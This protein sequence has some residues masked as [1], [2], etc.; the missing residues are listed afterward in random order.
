[1]TA[2]TFDLSPQDSRMLQDLARLVGKDESAFAGD[3]VRS[4]LGRQAADSD[5]RAGLRAMEKLRSETEKRIPRP[6]STRAQKSTRSRVAQGRSLA[7][8]PDGL[9]VTFEGKRAR[10]ESGQLELDGVR[11][12]SPSPAAVRAAGGGSYNGW[13]VWKDRKGRPLA[14]IHQQFAGSR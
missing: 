11:F 8:L 9:E 13:V 1:M 12:G 2:F 7:N 6:S 4:Y 3:I 14:E 10:V 5:V